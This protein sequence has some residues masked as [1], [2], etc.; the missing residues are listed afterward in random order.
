MKKTVV[1]PNHDRALARA[2]NVV[3]GTV[4]DMAANL[5]RIIRGN[6][7]PHLIYDQ[8]GDFYKSVIAFEELNKFGPGHQL[9]EF[10]R[11]REPTSLEEWEAFLV[12][13]RRDREADAIHMIC[14]GA[15]QYVASELVGQRLQSDAGMAELLR[16]VDALNKARSE[17]ERPAG[18]E[19]AS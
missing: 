14:Q 17:V 16:G 13:K 2:T 18:I 11:Y 15:L 4:R 8:M 9:N 3:K 5:L 19:P 6:G 7:Y 1:D 10:L 12:G